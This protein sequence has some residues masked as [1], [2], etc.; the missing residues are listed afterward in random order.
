MIEKPNAVIKPYV[1][2]NFGAF[3]QMVG[4]C[5]ADEYKIP[6][7]D[8]QL[9]GLCK[10]ITQSAKDGISFIALLFVD[11]TSIGFIQYQVDSPKSDWCEKEGY[12]CIREMYIHKDNRKQ[13]H[14]RTLATHAENELKKLSVPYIYLTSDDV[15]D[16]WLSVGYFD[17]GDVCKKNGG[18]ILVKRA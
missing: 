10:E 1:D 13:G 5:F 2:S 6:L 8:K 9:V 11:N 16:F 4:V 14:G 7:T 15:I 3:M 18:N 17:T 12:G